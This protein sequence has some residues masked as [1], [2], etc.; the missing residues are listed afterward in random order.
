MANGS[1][2]PLGE[3][4]ASFEQRFVNLEGAVHTL[5][6]TVE[7]YFSERRKSEDEKSRGRLPTVIAIVAVIVTLMGIGVTGFAS[8]LVAFWFVITM[9]I[10]NQTHPI[11]DKQ[12]T[13][14]AIVQGLVKTVS[15][16]AAESQRVRGENEASKTDRA[17]L[18]TGYTLNT[19]A[20]ADLTALM[21][22]ERAERRANEVEVETQIDTGAQNE[23]VK[24]AQQ[25]RKLIELQDTLS[26]M[27]G[28]TPHSPQEP[29]VY[30]NPSNR[31]HNKDGGGNGH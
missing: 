24:N 27:G 12:A 26:E 5:T 17:D 13:Q 25:D 31:Q 22:Q 8:A 7:S 16:Q 28:K 9:Q 20:I 14:E 19:K 21:S 3:W 30:P 23:N 10:N 1:S 15:D 18:R 4:R 29:Y 2:T 6:K 11:S